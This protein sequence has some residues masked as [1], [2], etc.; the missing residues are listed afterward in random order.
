M[1]IIDIAQNIDKSEKNREDID[2]E[3]LFNELGIPYSL[4]EEPTDSRLQSYWVGNWCCTDTWVGYRIYFFDDEPVAFSIQQ[5]RK[6]DEEFRWFSM[7]AAEKVRDYVLSFVKPKELSIAF[8]DINEDIGN[9]YKIE[10]ASDVIDWSKA[11]Y[12][13]YPIE[14]CEIIKD[15]EDIYNLDPTL[16]IRLLSTGEE[17]IV[18]VKD[19]DFVYHLNPISFAPGD[20]CTYSFGLENKSSAI[21]EIVKILD[22]AR[23]VAEI[24]FLEVIEDDTGNGFFNYLLKTGGTMNASFKYLKK[25]E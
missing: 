13:D 4:D 14:L 2:F 23:G 5:G 16:R 11:R 6:W 15:K 24:K 7:D 18:K 22:D 8:C 1:R 10:F 19:L 12:M 3:V 25:K 17:R 21:V 20:I 9:T